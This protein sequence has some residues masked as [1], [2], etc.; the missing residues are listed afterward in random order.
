MVCYGLWL[1]FFSVR[2]EAQTAMT[3]PG[4]CTTEEHRELKKAVGEACK[5][6]SMQ[7]GEKD[8]CATLWKSLL[9]RNVCHRGSAT[10]RRSMFPRWRRGPSPR[11]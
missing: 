11:D 6:V 9:Q 5:S 4:D 3:P 2:A 10:R 7:C 8:D 1:A